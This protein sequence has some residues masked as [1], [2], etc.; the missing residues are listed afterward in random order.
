M[1][2]VVRVRYEKGVLNPL[3]KLELSEGEYVLVIIKRKRDSLVELA[4]SLR[5]E[6]KVDID[7]LIEEVRRRGKASGY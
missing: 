6:A 1:S 5:R 4:R 7:R 2:R 3:E